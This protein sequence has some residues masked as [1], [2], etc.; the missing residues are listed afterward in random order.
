[1]AFV[2]ALLPIF[3]MGLGALGTVMT[4]QSQAAGMEF[5]A[6][7]DQ[8][9]A[10]IANRNAEITNQQTAS[11]ED[12]LRRE[13]RQQQGALRAA[14]GQAGI[15]LLGSATDVYRQST[16]NAEMDALNLRY[17][18]HLESIGLLNQSD[19]LRASAAMGRANA[20]ATRTAGYIGAATTLLMGPG[21]K[22]WGGK[23]V[24]AVGGA[25]NYQGQAQVQTGWG[26]IGGGP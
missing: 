14:L 5:Q 1:M 26:L 6:K 17:A 23:K 8:R 18:G 22:G 25:T 19:A 24:P 12:S 15:G 10:D 2:A 3:S 16:T 21:G 4:A 9:N 13:Q 20:S 7:I 11:R